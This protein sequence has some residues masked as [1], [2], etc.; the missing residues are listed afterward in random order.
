MNF[1][2]NNAHDGLAVFS[3]IYYPAGWKAYVDGKETDIIK[4]DYLLRGLYLTAGKHEIEFK[5]HPETYFKWGKVSLV[6]SILI[7]LICLA[8]FGLSLRDGMKKEIA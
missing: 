1:S 3:D 7:L 5:F 8:G 2:S 4:T 6:S